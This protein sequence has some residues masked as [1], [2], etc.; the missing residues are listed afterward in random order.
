MVEGIDLLFVTSIVAVVSE[1]LDRSDA[2]SAHDRCSAY[3]G[4]ALISVT[5]N[6]TVVRR[7]MRR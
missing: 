1:A 7:P 2:T 6:A 5:T 4:A 3:A